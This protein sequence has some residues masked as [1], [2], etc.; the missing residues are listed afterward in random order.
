MANLLGAV[1][2]IQLVAKTFAVVGNSPWLRQCLQGYPCRSHVYGFTFE[3]VVCYLDLNEAQ[4]FREQDIICCNTFT[5][6]MAVEYELHIC[7]S[8]RAH[9]CVVLNSYLSQ[10]NA[11]ILEAALQRTP[12]EYL[13]KLQGRTPTYGVHVEMPLVLLY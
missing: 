4:Q 5:L 3:S 6:L 10:K 7:S 2:F 12:R 1:Y 8:E 11:A 9:S 13:Y